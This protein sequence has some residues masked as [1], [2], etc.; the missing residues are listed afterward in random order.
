MDVQKS[1]NIGHLWDENHLVD[2]HLTERGEPEEEEEEEEEGQA[3][4]WPVDTRP[5]VG[6]HGLK[7][8]FC[9][10]ETDFWPV[11]SHGF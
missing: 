9:L 3:D 6:G 2:V 11:A 10:V 7:V 4:F 8:R 5:V 1:A